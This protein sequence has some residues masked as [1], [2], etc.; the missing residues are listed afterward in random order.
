MLGIRNK[1]SELRF[2]DKRKQLVNSEDKI[3]FPRIFLPQKY[4][5]KRTEKL[6]LYKLPHSFF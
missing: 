3:P 2:S 5:V 6:T 1:D 4:S